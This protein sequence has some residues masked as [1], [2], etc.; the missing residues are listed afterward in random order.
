VHA[1]TA[2]QKCDKLNRVAGWPRAKI[3]QKKNREK[4]LH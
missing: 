4:N 2:V 1:A 3:D